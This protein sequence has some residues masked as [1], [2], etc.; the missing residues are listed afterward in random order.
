MQTFQVFYLLILILLTTTLIEAQDFFSKPRCSS[1]CGDVR[2]RYPFGIGS[3]CS[4]N[5]WFNIDCNSSTPY[6]SALNNVEVLDLDTFT[7]RVIVNI[8]EFKADCKNP[9]Q[10]SN[11]VLGANHGKSPFRISGSLNRFVVKGCGSATIMEEE[12]GTIVTGCSTTCGKDT[13]SDTNNCFGIGCC[14]TLIPRDLESYTF[15]LTGM[16]KKEGDG[17]CGSAFLLDITYLER[18]H[19]ITF[20]N[21]IYGDGLPLP[22]SLSWNESFNLSSTR[23]NETCGEI[24][25]PYPFGIQSLCSES[26]WFNV[27][28]KSSK[29]YLSAI[30]NVEVLAFGKETVTVNVSMNSDCENP[31]QNNNLDLSKSPFSF[32][33]SDNIFVV[34]GCGSATII[35]NGSIV[36]GCS[37]A[38]GNATVSDRNNCFG[39][40]CCQSTIPRNL[41][42]F[43]LDLSRLGRQVGNET[44]GSALLV[45]MNSFM[46]ERFSR[47]FVPITLGWP[48][49]NFYDSTECRWCERQGG[50]C[51]T[52]YN[53]EGRISFGSCHGSSKKSLGVI[54]GKIFLILKLLFIVIHV[55]LIIFYNTS[56]TGFSHVF[57]LLRFS[58]KFGFV[59]TN[60]CIFFCQMTTDIKIYPIMY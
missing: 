17:T 41:E 23:C 12:N 33:K 16:A 59:N 48:T 7:Q 8:P 43:T 58:Y 21:Q 34:E 51:Y 35:E 42:S 28:C 40:G 60:Q 32:S 27:D 14:Q 38:C 25:I 18:R 29:P 2:I 26:D 36:S 46:E 52:N 57:N 50:I 37:T 9:V 22:T 1:R 49:I 30:N 31:V 20:P 45:D 53:E 55:S 6:L 3:N 39:N 54:L 44:C 47:Q 4:A 56:L 5:D 19:A 15:N 24:S 11:L 13:V 10:N